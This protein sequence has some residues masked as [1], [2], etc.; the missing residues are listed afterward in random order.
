MIMSF[1]SADDVNIHYLEAGSNSPII[2]LH[3][4]SDSSQFWE[5]LTNTLPNEY[6][7]ISPDLR[8]HGRSTKTSKIT[9]DLFTRDLNNLIN[10][11][12]IEKAVI[13]GFSLGA[14]IALNFTL[15]HPD[16]VKSLI[17]MSAYSSTSSDTR[18]KIGYLQKVTNERGVDG[19]FDEMIGLVYPSEF[20]I[21]Q[22]TIL[23]YKTIA[24]NN[25]STDSLIRSLDVCK[26]FN[27][28]DKLGG[29]NIKTLIIC[30][31]EDSFVSN[32]CS[33]DLYQNIKNSKLIELEDAGHNILVPEKINEVKLEVV[34]F[35][36]ESKDII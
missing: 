11:L 8:G 21:D 35:L 4:L 18:K 5:Q 14:L 10:T 26:N 29:I 2:F 24:V 19:F 3:G 1:M 16:K 7:I 13:I 27:V 25:N 28:K 9:M 6:R 33:E 36:K 31:I 30:G 15:E 22:S 34:K 32:H 17:L 20:K 12:G 23:K